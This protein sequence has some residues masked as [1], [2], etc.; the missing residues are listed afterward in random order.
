M[1][2]A[3]VKVV[4]G[5]CWSINCVC[6]ACVFCGFSHAPGVRVGHSF[7][8]LFGRAQCASAQCVY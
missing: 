6:C 3:G 5:V 7:V 4:C 2:V 8:V 1:G